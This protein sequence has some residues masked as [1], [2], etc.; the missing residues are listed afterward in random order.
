M[1]STDG[2]STTLIIDVGEELDVRCKLL[3]K[4]N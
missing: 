3:V 1:Y 4:V 2:S